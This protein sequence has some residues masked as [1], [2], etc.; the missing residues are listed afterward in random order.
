MKFIC[1]CTIHVYDG[2]STLVSRPTIIIEAEDIEMAMYNVKEN[3]QIKY[4]KRTDCGL[5]SVCFDLVKKI[6]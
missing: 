6:D 2:V 1:H 3:L 5:S 4:S